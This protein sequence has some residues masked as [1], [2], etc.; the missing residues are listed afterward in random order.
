MVDYNLIMVYLWKNPHITGVGFHPLYNLN[1]QGPFFS[2]LRCY[3][4]KMCWLKPVDSTNSLLPRTSEMPEDVSWKWWNDIY[5]HWRLKRPSYGVPVYQKDFSRFANV[6]GWTKVWGGS[7]LQTWVED[8]PPWKLT[9]ICWKMMDG[10]CNFL[11]M[12]IFLG[13]G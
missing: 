5:V 1:N 13:E 10:R 9:N 4:S 8:L 2:L 6:S 3:F 12:V 11:A 7:F